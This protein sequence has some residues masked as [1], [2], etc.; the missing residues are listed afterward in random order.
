MPVST[1]HSFLILNS[2][3]GLAER[4]VNLLL[5][6]WLYQYLIKRI[7]P[8]EYSL[9]PVVTALLVFIPPVMAVLTSGLARYAVEAYTRGD[10]LQITE[11]TSTIFPVLLGA[12][13][14]LAVVGAILTR[15]LDYVL[16]I[17]PHHLSDARLMVLL[18]FGS[19]ALR[20]MLTPFGVG[21]YVCQQFVILNALN[22]VQTLFRLGLLVA[23]L[24][25]ISAHVIWVVVA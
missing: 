20:F 2:A 10:Y 9:Y 21:L 19:L 13:L 1:K 14:V 22:L 7:S 16:K 24:L 6:V 23:L 4:I 25:G 5:Q 11:I 3:S 18:L 15:Y 8:E 12:G 17:A